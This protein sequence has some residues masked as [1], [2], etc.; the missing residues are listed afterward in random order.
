LVS[1]GPVFNGTANQAAV[2]LGL[3]YIVTGIGGLVAIVGLWMY[4]SWA[5][6]L[7][8]IFC[9]VSILLG[10]LALSK[11]TS[12]TNL[13]MQIFTIGLNIWIIWYLMRPQTKALFTHGKK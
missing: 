12:G 1:I 5:N 3:L 13:L 9:L 2:Y 10:L 8:R 11:N 7:T 6:L 4:R